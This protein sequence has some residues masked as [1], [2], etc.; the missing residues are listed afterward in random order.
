MIFKYTVAGALRNKLVG[1]GRDIVTKE[2][3]IL[4]LFGPKFEE[5]EE[6]EIFTLNSDPRASWKSI[7]LVPYKF[8]R[9]HRPVHVSGAIYWLTDETYHKS[10]VVIV[11]F[12]LHTEKFQVITHP[13]IFES[14]PR[15][16]MDLVSLR[17]C[18]CLAE[19]THDFQLNIWIMEESV[20][21][22]MLHSIHLLSSMELGMSFRFCF[23]IAE[24]EDGTIILICGSKDNLYLYDP[25]CKTFHHWTIGEG[26]FMPTTYIE[27]LVP[28]ENS[29]RV[30]V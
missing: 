30:W 15:R 11:M 8:A 29:F 19:Q 26:K 14:Q 6:G 24:R 7:G 27:S 5:F 1:I 13:N 16:C 12:D 2:Y 4:R 23:S 22:K 28:L 10:E 20:I 9:S 3:K 17:G 18:L 21:W 25:K